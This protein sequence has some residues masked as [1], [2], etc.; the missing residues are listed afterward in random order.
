MLSIYEDVD[1]QKNE[2]EQSER[3]ETQRLTI[4]SFVSKYNAI[5]G[6]KK[7]WI[8]FLLFF[9]TYDPWLDIEDNLGHHNPEYI[10]EL[11][12]KIFKCTKSVEY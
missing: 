7:K 3:D 4:K 6:I 2:D 1:Y 10:L 8:D 11:E 9:N 5:T 12:S